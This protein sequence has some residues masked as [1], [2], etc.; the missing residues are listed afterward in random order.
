MRSCTRRCL[1]AY[2][3]RRRNARRVVA[4]AMALLLSAAVFQG[5]R[6]PTQAARATLIVISGDTQG[7]ITPCGCT[8]NQSGGLLRRATYLHELRASAD[9]L[10]FDAGGA[11]A[12]D[13]PFELAKLE[14]T[15]AGES[16]MGICAHNIGGSELAIGPE[17]L[18][19]IAG[20]AH[21]PLISANVRL[22]DGSALAPAIRIF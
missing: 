3:S 1:R 10:Y 9:V 14:A 19:R 2:R 20:S 6:Q 15:L 5:C 13:S 16:E 21:V 11:G 18:Q 22:A 4:A 17:A 8:A 7:W 12:G